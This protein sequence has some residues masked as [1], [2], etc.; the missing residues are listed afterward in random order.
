[1]NLVY[2]YKRYSLDMKAWLTAP[3]DRQTDRQNPANLLVPNWKTGMGLNKDEMTTFKPFIAIFKHFLTLDNFECFIITFKK[4]F[5]NTT[6]VSSNSLNPDQALHFVDLI[7]VHSKLFA[8]VISKQQSLP[9]AGKELM[10]Q[11]YIKPTALTMIWFDIRYI[12]TSLCIEWKMCT[13][14]LDKRV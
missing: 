11:C 12:N 9:P 2:P 8:K 4:S 10:V 3:T 5:S 14:L 6:R 1:M 13:R 7:R